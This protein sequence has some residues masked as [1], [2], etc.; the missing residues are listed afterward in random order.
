MM[1]NSPLS[2]F[3]LGA[4]AMTAQLTRLNTIAS[5]V[6]NAG[7]MAGSSETAYRAL[8]PVFETAYTDATESAGLATVDVI[9]IERSTREVP[10]VLQPGNPLA[11][12]NGYVYLSNVDVSEELVDMV[13]TS[14]QYQNTIEALNTTKS[15]MV[16][17]LRLAS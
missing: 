14:R 2:A 12:D 10:R 8:R 9:D 1:A 16:A 7:V 4:R 6:A 3:D 5:N 15:L 11:D 13:E 17:T